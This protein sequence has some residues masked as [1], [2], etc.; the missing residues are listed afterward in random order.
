MTDTMLK[1]LIGRGLLPL[2]AVVGSDEAR[3]VS[4]RSVGGASLLEQT[5]PG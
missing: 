3:I 1:E 4:L 5:I 2:A